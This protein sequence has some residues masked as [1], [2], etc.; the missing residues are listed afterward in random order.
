MLYVDIPCK[1]IFSPV[2]RLGKIPVRAGHY[3]KGFITFVKQKKVEGQMFSL[4]LILID[5]PLYTVINE[6]HYKNTSIE[7]QLQPKPT[8]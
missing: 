2:R 4:L 6:L 5:V 3:I 7:G 1:Y 8:F